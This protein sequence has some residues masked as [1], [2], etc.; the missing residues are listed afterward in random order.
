M[1]TRTTAVSSLILCV[2]SSTTILSQQKP[3]ASAPPGVQE[4]PVVMQQNIAAGKTPVGTKIQAKLEV[5]TF[6]DG[7]VVPRNAVF[8]GEVVESAAKTA[9]D[10]SRL[11]IRID[12]VLW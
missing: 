11:A 3:A 8:T 5:A 1:S 6:I 2:F 12:S 7:T 10:P 4:F 9:A